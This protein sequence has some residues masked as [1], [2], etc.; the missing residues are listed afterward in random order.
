VSGILG[1]SRP[2]VPFAVTHYNPRL[3]SLAG[4]ARPRIVTSSAA[5]RKPQYAVARDGRFLI[6]QPVKEATAT[7]ITMLVN[8]NP[9]AKK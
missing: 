2:H 7:P 8:W 5:A 1:Y 3:L 4:G 6:N 9:E